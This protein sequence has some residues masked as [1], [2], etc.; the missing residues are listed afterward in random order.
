LKE[1]LS[2]SIQFFGEGAGLERQSC[3]LRHFGKEGA[4]S[5]SV[6]LSQEKLW[7]KGWIGNHPT[8]RLALQ[9]Q[10]R[11]LGR[12]DTNGH[13]EGNNSLLK[14]AVLHEKPY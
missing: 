8:P 12:S 4:R 5:R 7:A 2:T 14:R 6:Q 1:D 9:K 13:I 10:L 3:W 11:K